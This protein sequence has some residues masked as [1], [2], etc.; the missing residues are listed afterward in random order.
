[1]LAAA[2]PADEIETGASLQWNF[3]HSL[4]TDGKYSGDTV[5]RNGRAP[6]LKVEVFEDML[7]ILFG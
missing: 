4:S 5:G 3:E 2:V 1:M 6:G 7:D